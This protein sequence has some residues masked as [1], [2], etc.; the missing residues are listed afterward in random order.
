V[1]YYLALKAEALYLAHRASEALET[2]G[3]AETLV[4]RS[5]ERW[6]YAELH[7]L[8][9]VFLATIGAE[10]TLIEASPWPEFES[11]APSCPAFKNYWWYADAFG[12]GL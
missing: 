5:G 1:P 11:L 6:W 10:K 9:G 4:E 2:I 8:R 3:A 12:K 7:R